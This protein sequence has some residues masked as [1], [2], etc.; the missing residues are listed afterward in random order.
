MTA[1]QPSAHSS[2][3]APLGDI[4]STAQN[5]VSMLTDTLSSPG[6]VRPL[7][8]G[9]PNSA[10]LGVGQQKEGDQSSFSGQSAQQE[11]RSKSN[12]HHGHSVQQEMARSFPGFFRKE[13]RGKKRFGP[14]KRPEKSLL[15]VFFLLDQQ[16]ERTPKGE[17]E[18]ELTLAG[19]GRRSLTITE[20]ITH[21]ELSEVLVN[22]YPKLA[23]ICGGW[24][25]HKCSGGGGQRKLIVI[26]PD[27][28]GYNG[29]QLKAVSSNGKCTMYI[30]PLQ[31]QIDTTP[32]PPDAKEFEKMPKA[33]C[34]MCSQMVPLQ[35][36]PMHIKSCEMKWVDLCTSSDDSMEKTPQE[37]NSSYVDTLKEELE[38]SPE[39]E[40]CDSYINEVWTEKTAECPLCKD[41]FNS[42][43]IEIHAA[44]CGLRT[45]EYHETDMIN[46]TEPMNTLQS[47]G[48]ILNWISSKVDQT[49]TFPI[50][51]SRSDIFKRGMQQWQRQKKTSPKCRL[52]VTFFGEAGVD[53][54][55][56]SKEFLTEMIAVIETR[57][58]ISGV[59]KRGKNPVYCLNSL[60]R[61]YSGVQ[62][63]SW[64]SV[65]HKVDHHLC[66][67]AS[68]AS[69]IFAL[70]IMTVYGCLP[71]MSQIW[72]FHCLLTRAIVLHSTMRVVP[73]L[74][75]LRKGLQLYDLQKVM[76]MHPDLCL[77]LFVPGEKDD[78][79]DAA[80][81]LE[82]SHP[83]FSEKG[84]VKYSKEI[85]VMNFLQDFLQ[86][87]EDCGEQ[88][89]AGKVMQ[90]MTGQRHKPI[91]PSDQKDF[92][93]TVTH[94][95]LCVFQL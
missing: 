94:F 17:S 35:C 31:E 14:Y 4:L 23:N 36:L 92:N 76:G 37:D 85:N 70:E 74:E 72:N 12:C 77:P 18:L 27:P 33:Q 49:N 69:N 47:S 87:I 57:L 56:L 45:A 7:R 5:L 20:N 93:I 81:I 73:M 8:Q 51:V 48:E 67:C 46:L 2:S 32:L 91:L 68:G 66:F 28:D 88:M 79:V 11:R 59:D 38:K 61:N 95:I 15:M 29:Q 80:F 75:Q 84:S 89:T 21:S 43:V 3:Q 26:P 62:E 39:F 30:V 53:S 25:L 83:V 64:Q 71:V 78:R 6:N 44:H 13:V 1:Q 60:D 24:L 42:D 10:E 19:L 41:I 22:A 86:E 90:W 52:K 9:R 16:Y 54:G 63:K 40:S 82:N 55:A 34:T 50:C 58:F 65:W